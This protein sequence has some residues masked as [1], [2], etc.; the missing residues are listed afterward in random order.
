M[1]E[2]IYLGGKIEKNC[3]RHWLVQGLHGA[4]V[5]EAGTWPV[6]RDAIFH[7]HDYTGPFFVSCDHGCYHGDTTH[8]LGIDLPACSGEGEERDVVVDRCLTAIRG[9]SFVF[10]WLDGPEAYGTIAEMGFAKGIGVP[11]FAGVSYQIGR[12]GYQEYHPD[13]GYGGEVLSEELTWQR[14]CWFPLHLADHVFHADGPLDAL[15]RTLRLRGHRPSRYEVLV[16]PE[17]R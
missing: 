2:Q 17:A 11:I 7:E 16:D 5:N 15:K 4:L 1:G 6:L 9:S 8:G 13:S 3:W 14:E 12:S 10:V